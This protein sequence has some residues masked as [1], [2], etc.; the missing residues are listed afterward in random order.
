M[1]RIKWHQVGEKVYENGVSHGVLYQIDES[2]LYGAA[3]AWNGL[4][5]VTESPSGA[6]STKQY[7]DNQVYLNMLSIEEFNATIEAYTYPD[8]FAV[9]EGTLE[10]APGVLVGQQPRKPFG[11]CYRTK[12]GNDVVG[13]EFAYK[14]HLVYGALA[15]PTEKAYN[16]INESPEA[17][18]FSWELSTTPV[19]VPGMAPSASIVIDSRTVDPD[20]LAALE[21]ILYGKDAVTTPTPAPAVVGRLPLPSE[22]ATIFT[23]P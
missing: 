3:E 12:I 17:A 11:L 19:E 2:G 4:T 14:L 13:Q 18:T 6:E 8:S 9:N 20:E 23:T 1:S 7:A 10:L 22:L 15:A 21:E 5:A 16:T